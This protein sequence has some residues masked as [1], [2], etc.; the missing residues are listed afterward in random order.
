MR[1]RL[2]HSTW[3]TAARRIAGSAL[4]LG[5]LAS[6]GCASGGSTTSARLPASQ[7]EASTS[8]ANEPGGVHINVSL[9]QRRLYLK[10]GNE[11]VQS[12]SIGVGKDGYA[13]PQGDYSVSRIVWNPPW[14]P[15]NSDWAADK[16][17]EP[18]GSPD[19]LMKTVKIYFKEPDYYIHG[20][21]SMS[22][23]GGAVSHG[24]LRMAPSEAASLARYLMEHGGSSRDDSWFRNV[25]SSNETQNVSLS[26]AVPM[27][28]AE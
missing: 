10:N 22:S 19:N 7:P 26:R 18:P 25:A 11:T 28:V 23:L 5:T 4:T 20:T 15:P 21:G 14:N 6:L 16:D 1:T 17:P 2:D 27:H 3:Y 13:T 9:S 12:Y 24:C 8:Y